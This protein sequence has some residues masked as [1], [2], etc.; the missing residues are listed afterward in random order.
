MLSFNINTIDAELIPFANADQAASTGRTGKRSIA[1]AKDMSAA[2]A[3]HFAGDAVEME[4]RTLGNR[5]VGDDIPVEL[6]RV[7]DD[8]RKL[9]DHKIDVCNLDRVCF[10]GM[11]QG[12]IQNTLG[13]G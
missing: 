4:A 11:A 5:P 10:F 7:V 2:R 6:Y 8:G 13:H 1:G 9:P 12:N 3:G